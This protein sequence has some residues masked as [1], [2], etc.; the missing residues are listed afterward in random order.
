MRRASAA[1]STAPSSR[2]KVQSRMFILW[3]QTRIVSHSQ[4]EACPRHSQQGRKPF[5]TRSGFAERASFYRFPD[6]E[7][8]LSAPPRRLS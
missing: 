6:H 3:L 8:V 2:D 4:H 5:F 1:S 7:R